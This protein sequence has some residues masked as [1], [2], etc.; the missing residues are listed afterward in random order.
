M[1]VSN[2]SGKR[3]AA[4]PLRTW[5]GGSGRRVGAEAWPGEG[6]VMDRVGGEQIVSAWPG[7]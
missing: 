7:N 6:A 3:F 4:P 1:R 5:V 2:K